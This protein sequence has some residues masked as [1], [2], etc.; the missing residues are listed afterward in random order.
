MR[1]C[2][3]CGSENWDFVGAKQLNG[4]PGRFNHKAYRC[5]SCGRLVITMEDIETYGEL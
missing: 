3:S 5:K 4:R 2:K 1:T